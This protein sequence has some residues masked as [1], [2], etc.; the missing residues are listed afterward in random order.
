MSTKRIIIP[1]DALKEKKEKL[2][3]INLVKY[4]SSTTL[5]NFEAFLTEYAIVYILSGKKEIT[6]SDTIYRI[7]KGEL[8]LLPKGEYIMSEYVTGDEDFQSITLYFNSKISQKALSEIE[9][10]NLSFS[11]KG[12]D[13]GNAIHTIPVTPEI[14]NIFQSL[15]SYI[16]KDFSFRQEL[17]QLKFMELI[18]LLL[19]DV[20]S[21]R[22]ILFLLSAARLDKPD[23]SSIISEY[24]YTPVT[25]DKLAVLTGRSISQFKRDFAQL[26]GIPPHQWITKKKLE[27]AAF[28]LKTSDKN[29]DL[30]S[31]ACGFVNSTHFSRIFKKEY[32]ISP[33]KYTTK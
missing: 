26:Y 14:E 33:S 19:N 7:G 16:E 1:Q 27:Y 28:L 8:F 5:A 31:D 23:I 30:I 15:I 9:M 21:G 24:L 17:I 10:S 12:K 4:T 20:V 11:L 25:I 29:I 32:G 2:A 18:F 6:V 3:N 13:S 22:I